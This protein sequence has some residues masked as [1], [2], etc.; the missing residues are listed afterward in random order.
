MGFLWI[1]TCI[2]TVFAV[3]AMAVGFLA[4]SAPMQ[5][6]AFACACALAVVPYVFTR[7]VQEIIGKKFDDHLEEIARLLKSRPDSSV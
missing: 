7:A 1:A 4:S 5:A 6:A 2:S 3:L